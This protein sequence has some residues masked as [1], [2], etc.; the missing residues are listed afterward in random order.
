MRKYLLLFILLQF[1][2]CYYGT[3]TEIDYARLD[4][5]I[6]EPT[7]SIE[8]IELYW[9]GTNQPDKKYTQ[10]AVLEAK[11]NQEDGLSSLLHQLKLKGQELGADALINI[12]T[13]NTIRESGTLLSLIT[14]PDDNDATQY[15]SLVMTCVAIK[16]K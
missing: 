2:G 13:T 15:Y 12:K 9:D 4:S 7:D 11:G 6:Y 16:Y 1:S 10:V 3:N 5:K 14:N 8:D